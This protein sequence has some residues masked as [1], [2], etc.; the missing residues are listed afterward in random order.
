MR[1]W[2]LA[3]ASLAPACGLSVVG[4]DPEGLTETLP[5]GAVITLPPG[6]DG[7]NTVVLEDGR[8]V[9][10]PPANEAGPDAPPATT[11][12]A[13]CAGGT[14]DAKGVCQL[15]GTGPAQ[16]VCPPGVPCNVTCNDDECKGGIDC[17]KASSCTIA[18]NGK[19]SCAAGAIA[20]AGSTCDVSCK[21]DGSCAG[22]VHCT[23]K[24]ECD[25]HCIG[26]MTCGTAVTC[27]K[28][29]D[30][31]IECTE[32]RTCVDQVS[33]S[34]SGTCEVSCGHPMSC[35]GQKVTA[36]GGALSKVTCADDACQKGVSV[37]ASINGNVTC[38]GKAACGERSDCAATTCTTNCA[39][40]QNVCSIALANLGGGCD[41]DCH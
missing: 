7:G 15:T 41:T 30:C 14:C 31:T 37:H 2:I 20:C 38:G 4:V 16:V 39:H 9:V 1:R 3:V 13:A 21:A 17:T 12:A 29:S 36:S 11:C 35:I 25:L 24:D 22:G 23:A 18:C 34:A 8:V 19:G 5:D 27:D 26:K 6:S 28:P 32:D 40:Q 33:C 10:I